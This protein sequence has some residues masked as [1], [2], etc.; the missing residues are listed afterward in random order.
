[1]KILGPYTDIVAIIGAAIA[2]A[3]GGYEL[4]GL[5][6]GSK[7]FLF[8]PRQI[9]VVRYQYPQI[10]GQYLR[11]SARMAYANSGQPGYNSIIVEEVVK[12]TLDGREFEQVGQ[13]YETFRYEAGKLVKDFDSDAKPLPV[14]GGSS[15]SHETFFAPQPISCPE[16]S[17]TCDPD[18]NFLEWHEFIRLADHA[19]E[20]EF[21]LIGV[22]HD[23]RPV[24]RKCLKRPTSDAIAGMI[25]TKHGILICAK[26]RA[27]RGQ[28][29][30]WPSR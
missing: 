23:E 4:S 27:R 14:N 29:G 28:A 24:T 1:M 22:L 25:A 15:E 8:P 11:L 18:R 6:A 7:T 9:T 3:T 2:L 17:E 12:F 30:R 20:I 13:S 10:A 19:D 5:L 16:A 21:T 26:A